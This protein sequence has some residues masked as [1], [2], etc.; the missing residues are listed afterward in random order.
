MIVQE[1][2]GLDREGGAQFIHHE[3]SIDIRNRAVCLTGLGGLGRSFHRLNGRDQKPQI[4]LEHFLVK[5]NRIARYS[6]CK[7]LDGFRFL[8]T[9]LVIDL[10]PPNN[11]G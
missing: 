8:F 10:K 3:F 2:I 7:C 11:I 6:F 1:F 4:Q 9:I 5:L